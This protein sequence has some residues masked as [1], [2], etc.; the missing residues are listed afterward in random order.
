MLVCP[1]QRAADCPVLPSS[2]T[3]LSIDSGTR[4]RRGP[5]CL[6]QLILRLSVRTLSLSPEEFSDD[7]LHLCH[8]CRSGLH[9]CHPGCP[10]F[11]T[12]PSVTLPPV[13]PTPR[14]TPPTISAPTQ[15]TDLPK[16]SPKGPQ[17]FR[18][19]RQHCLPARREEVMINYPLGLVCGSG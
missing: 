15:Q 4:A 1:Q 18:G 16:C 14:P 2:V 11:L 12:P 5:S 9:H 10:S 3:S 8:F 7:S 19:L 17:L 6:P 13:P